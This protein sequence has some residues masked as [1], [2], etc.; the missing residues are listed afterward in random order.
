M[1]P[2]AVLKQAEARL[3]QLPERQISEASQ[4][5]YRRVVARM[6]KAG[7]FDP[8]ASTRSRDTYHLRRSAFHWV[9]RER[10]AK[11]ISGLERLIRAR[12][13]RESRTAAAEL[14]GLIARID[15]V[16]A[17]HPAI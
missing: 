12:R 8:M 16:L 5:E 7:D 14:L 4:K 1:D 11:A 9:F 6:E 13:V 15:A 2:R 3:P 17:D 10:L